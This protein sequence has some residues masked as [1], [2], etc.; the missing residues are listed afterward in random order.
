MFWGGLGCFH[1]PLIYHNSREN[2]FNYRVKTF[3]NKM[4][5]ESTVQMQQ[6]ESNRERTPEKPVDREKV[7]K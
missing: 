6:N 3:P 4:A 5:L 7:V 1:G 2:V